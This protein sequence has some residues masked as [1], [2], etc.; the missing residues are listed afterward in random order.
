MQLRQDAPRGHSRIMIGKN[1]IVM[2]GEA[3]GVIPARALFFLAKLSEHYGR[4]AGEIINLGTP[5]KHVF[6]PTSGRAGADKMVRLPDMAGRAYGSRSC[7]AAGH[8]RPG[9]NKA[10]NDTSTPAAR[11]CPPPHL[12]ETFAGN[13]PIR[14]FATNDKAGLKESLSFGVRGVVLEAGG[15]RGLV[16]PNAYEVTSL[17]QHRGA[18]DAVYKHGY[19]HGEGLIATTS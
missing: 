2:L 12:F 8:I 6:P 11:I 4:I 14:R 3:M 19:K 18:R 7:D 15:A 13:R 17:L 5:H 16:F 1:A 9:G 10:D